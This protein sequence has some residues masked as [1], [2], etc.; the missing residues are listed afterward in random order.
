MYL[1][2]GGNAFSLQ[3]MLGH[4]SLGATQT[5]MHI[6][7]ADLETGHQEAS[8]VAGWRLGRG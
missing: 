5:Y 7:Q 6:A 3:A 1:R 8:P 4:S 2:N